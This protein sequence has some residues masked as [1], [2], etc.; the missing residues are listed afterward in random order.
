MTNTTLN[1]PC[2]LHEGKPNSSGYG[3][4]QWRDETGR[5]RHAYAHRV[6]YEDFYGVKIA[7]NKEIHH[8]CVNRTCVN[9]HHMV[10]VTRAEHRGI[11]TELRQA[12]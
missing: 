11:H 1:S 3:Q 5:K 7:P 10:Q 9:P 8:V 12:A 6:A 4:I 2:I